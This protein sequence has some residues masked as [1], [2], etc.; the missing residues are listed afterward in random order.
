MEICPARCRAKVREELRHRSSRNLPESATTNKL[1][2]IPF[3]KK[4]PAK[5]DCRHSRPA[6]DGAPQKGPAPAIL[7]TALAVQRAHGL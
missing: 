6:E 1:R 3:P 7:A 4:Q 2:P 5:P